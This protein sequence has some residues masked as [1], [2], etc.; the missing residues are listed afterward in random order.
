MIPLYVDMRKRKVLIFGGGDVAARKARLFVPEADVV[1]ASRSF[2]PAFSLMSLETLRFDTNL[3]DDK[4]I[5]GLITG[6]FLVISTLSDKEEND[7]IGRICAR[8]N[9]LFNNADGNRGDVIVPSVTGGENY[10]LAISTGGK[11]PAIS[12]FVRELVERE[13]PNLD[14]MI[15]LQ[16]ELRENL[17]EQEPSQHRRAEILEKILRDPSIWADLADDPARARKEAAARYLV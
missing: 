4:E 16:E 2:L 15:A 9:I 13:L 11:S 8:H 3:A 10:T 12:R 7:R 5:S 6:S 14:R 1:I 17:K